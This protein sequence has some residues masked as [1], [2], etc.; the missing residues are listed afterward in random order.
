M[1]LTPGQVR[2]DD[3]IRV[4]SSGGQMNHDLLREMLVLFIEENQ[5][6]VHAAVRAAD[7]GDT[8][9]LRGVMHAV[10][11][12]AA[13]IGAE[14]LR[15][16]AGDCELRIISGTIKDPQVHARQLHDE[17]TAVVSTLRSLYPDLSAR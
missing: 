2:L 17:F 12:S 10:K 14:H 8:P 1:P 7:E 13:L 15:D 11:G 4:C 16:L 5:R 3:L 6:R 9:A